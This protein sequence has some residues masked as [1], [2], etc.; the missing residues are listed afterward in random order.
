MAWAMTKDKAQTLCALYHDAGTPIFSH[1]ID[2]KMGDGKNQQSSERKIIDVIG[3]DKQTLELL[4]Q[5]NVKLED[6][7]DS[8][9]YPI[10]DKSI[11]ALCIDRLEGIFATGLIW[12]QYLSLEDIKN[13][14]NNIYVLDSSIRG[15]FLPSCERAMNFGIELGIGDD[16]AE[17]F[18]EAIVKYSILLQTSEDKFS[19]ELLGKI[20]NVYEKLGVLREEYFYTISEA[21]AIE[22][23]LNSEYAYLWQDFIKMKEVKPSNEAGFCMKAEAKFRQCAPLVMT[24]YGPDVLTSISGD[25]MDKCFEM[26]CFYHD[27]KELMLTSDLSPKSIRL[28]KRIV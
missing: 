9:K 13:F 14:Y 10:I 16:Y 22:K 8:K 6:I 24:P 15:W 27:H 28:L 11:P 19:M 2:F 26:L 12:G 21:Q 18:Y 4:K 20:L 25:A 3:N 17:E 5:D 1:A 7:V 23:M